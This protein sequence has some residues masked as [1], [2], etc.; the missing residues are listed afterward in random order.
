[1]DATATPREV[2]SAWSA[3]HAGEMVVGISSDVDGQQWANLSPETCPMPVEEFA[4]MWLEYLEG[5]GADGPDSVRCDED[6]EPIA[7]PWPS[8]LILE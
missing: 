4:G 6:G 3:L 1:M 2:W 7:S 8:G 5:C